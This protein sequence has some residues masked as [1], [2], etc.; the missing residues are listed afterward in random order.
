M[1]A[2]RVLQQVV[3]RSP[4]AAMTEGAPPTNRSR[5]HC[6]TLTGL[7][8]RCSSPTIP[9]DGPP[10]R[11]TPS[12]R[13]PVV[14]LDDVDDGLAERYRRDA[15]RFL[16]LGLVLGPEAERDPLVGWVGAE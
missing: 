4:F 10:H 7:G 12:R 6:P 8:V 16:A 13:R 15:A 14:L 11:E 5:A 1:L 9:D 2:S 3:V